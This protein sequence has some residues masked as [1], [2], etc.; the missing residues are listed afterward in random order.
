MKLSIIIPVYCNE[1]SLVPLFADLKAKVLDVV[2][3]EYEI[4]VIDDGST[5][6]SWTVME[7]LCER[8]DSITALRLSKNFGSHAAILC[9]LEHCTGDCAVV[10]AADLQEPSELILRM[11][12]KWKSGDNVVLAVRSEREE[13]KSKTAF[14]NMYYWLTRKMALPNMPKKGFDVYLVDRKVIDVLSSLDNTNS[15]LTGQILWSG[16]KTGIVE[17]TRKAREIGTS[18]WTLAKKLRLVS[19]TLFGFSTAPIKAVELVGA[20][21]F[22]GAL[23]WAIVV[24]VCRLS[25]AIDV[26]GWTSLFIFSLFSF[27]IIMV[28]LGI[29]GEYLWRVY[30]SSRGRPSYIVETKRSKHDGNQ[31]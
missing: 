27:G 16:F 15:A 4:V 1:D 8:D 13:E 22:F 28:T 7:R 31:R 12:S 23:I 30:D 2:D 18:K 20:I 11:V 9:G 19:D 3:Y 21:A 17:Y 26:D 5:D 29:L 24:F 14:A 25:G 6:N 10:K